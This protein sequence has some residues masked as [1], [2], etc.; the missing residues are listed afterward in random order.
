MIDDAFV[1]PLTRLGMTLASATRSFPT[2]YYPDS[3]IDDAADP[4]G[5]RQVVHAN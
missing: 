2:P 1:F 5:A 4:A 3:R